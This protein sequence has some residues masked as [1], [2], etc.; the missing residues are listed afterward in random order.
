MQKR[1]KYLRI[2]PDNMIKMTN[3]KKSFEKLIITQVS[4]ICQAKKSSPAKKKEHLVPLSPGGVRRPFY[5]VCTAIQ[6]WFN[7]RLLLLQFVFFIV[8]DHDRR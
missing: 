7:N 4:S 2:T 5:I 6:L 3:Q 1:C 8:G